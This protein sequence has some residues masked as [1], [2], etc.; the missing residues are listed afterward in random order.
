VAEDTPKTALEAQISQEAK[1]LAEVPKVPVQ[2][3]YGTHVRCHFCGQ[4]YDPEL[5]VSVD[6]HIGAERRKCPKCGGIDG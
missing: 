3:F 2:K 1:E 5:G 4:I 6:R